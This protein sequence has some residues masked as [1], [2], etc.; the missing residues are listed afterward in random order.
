MKK[1]QKLSDF[2]NLK[3]VEVS[4]YS[5]IRGGAYTLS[6]A[7]SGNTCRR[8]DDG[9]SSMPGGNASADYCRDHVR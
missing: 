2:N 3:Q 7:M 6:G 5:K 8:L 4:D 9:D 1:L